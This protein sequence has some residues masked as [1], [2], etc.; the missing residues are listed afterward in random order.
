MARI[1]SAAWSIAAVFI[2]A[3]SGQAIGADIRVQGSEDAVRVEAHD[4]TRSEILAALA[5][6][7]ALRYRG[8]TDGRGLTTTFEGPLREVVKRVLEGYNYVINTKDDGLD[9]IVVSPESTAAIPPPPPVRQGRQ[10]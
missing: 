3:L 9:V 1:V 5:G 10:E 2:A 8:A 4:A 6:R 7:F